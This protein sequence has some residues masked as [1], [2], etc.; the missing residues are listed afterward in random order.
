[1]DKKARL[2]EQAIERELLALP[3]WKREDEKRIRRAYLFA[4]FP[5]AIAFVGRVAELA[6]RVNHHPFIAIDYRRVTLTYTTWNAGGLTR[7]DFESARGCDALFG[8]AEKK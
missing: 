6:E 2:T 3:G 8:E 4:S 7:L 1:M 5:E